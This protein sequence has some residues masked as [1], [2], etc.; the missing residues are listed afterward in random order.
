[1]L[2]HHLLGLREPANATLIC[3]ASRVNFGPACYFASSL[4]C[5]STAHVLNTAF[6][7]ARR[8]IEYDAA[9]HDFVYL[10]AYDAPS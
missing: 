8:L 5:R 2:G 7:G 9:L 10:A 4:S 6:F 1:M 3:H